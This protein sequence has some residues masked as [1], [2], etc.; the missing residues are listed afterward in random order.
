[1]I[2]PA[3]V[4]AVEAGRYLIAVPIQ[5]LVP[6]NCCFDTFNKAR[7]VLWYSGDV[8]C[9]R[10]LRAA[11]ERFPFVTVIASTDNLKARTP[12]KADGFSTIKGVIRSASRRRV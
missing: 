3:A 9:P 10:V 8:A 6:S 12:A 5:A 7:A 4:N 11:G 1:M 2:N